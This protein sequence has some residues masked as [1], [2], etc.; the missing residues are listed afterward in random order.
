MLTL[1]IKLPR[2]RILTL[3]ARKTFPARGL[4]PLTFLLC[5]LFQPNFL[6]E[7]PLELLDQT[8]LLKGVFAVDLQLVD[9]D[10]HVSQPLLRLLQL[11][12][13]TFNAK[14]LVLYTSLLVLNV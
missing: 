3:G 6:S 2:D 13:V 12:D 11:R 1:A 9:L 8:A 4:A 5:Q 7:V 14:D 10:R